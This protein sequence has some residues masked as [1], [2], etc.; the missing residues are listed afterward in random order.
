[1]KYSAR[2]AISAIISILFI[3]GVGACQEPP[4]APDPPA[5]ETGSPAVSSQPDGTTANPGSTANSGPT[6]NPGS[7]ASSGSTAISG[8]ETPAPGTG[9]DAA[10]PG[11][12]MPESPDG[13]VEV[14]R[15][16]IELSSVEVLKGTVL[17]PVVTVLPDNATD[18]SYTLSSSDESVL[19]T[20]Y[21]YWT[22]VGGGAAQLIATA[23]NG[24][25]GTVTVNVI[26][27]VES[28]SLN[29]Y[30]ITMNC[31]DSASL[32][33]T[34]TP[35]DATDTSVHYTSDDEEVASVSED[36]TILA[37]NAGTA[38]IQC[39]VGSMSAS[40]AVT[41]II[42][43]AEI[44]I[45]VDKRIYEVGDHGSIEIEIRPED[46]TDK[47]YSVDISGAAITMTGTDSF[48]CDGSGEVTI[49]VTASNGVTARQTLIIVDLV[50]LADEVFRLTNVERANA[51]IAPLTMTPALT[52][53]SVL[54]ATEIIRYFS[55]DRPD[56][57]DCFT[58]FDENNV[59]YEI[60][61]EN[62]AMGQRTPAEV[63]SA[64]MNSAG[65]RANILKEE[66]GHLGV[67]VAMDSNG[68]FYWSQN[69]TD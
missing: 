50:A 42:P 55:H 64:W 51:G 44:N 69:F 8:T 4:V 54:R 9:D 35:A 67:G 21:G 37:V 43:V 30:E 32:T 15:I 62:I 60:A 24:V 57:R 13:P 11:S 2:R 38:N 28:L 45:N 36:G 14:E 6:A 23:A 5:T 46:A 18:K 27:P 3:M 48:S 7:T 33:P 49:T 22:A 47:T 20:R 16:I 41:V 56:G 19:H 66:Y 53:T 59:I 40:C 26:V 65:H 12:S 52:R 31:G 34:I 39:A 1:M 17:E 29:M 25:R 58:A 63:L 61:G 10:L 68:R